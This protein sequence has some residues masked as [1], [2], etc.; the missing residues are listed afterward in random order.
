MPS[1]PDA[2]DR[3][4][5]QVRGVELRTL[6]HYQDR[7]GALAVAEL[8]EM[9]PFSVERLFV[10]YAV[11]SPEVR[12]EHA[13]RALHQFLICVAGSCRVSVDDGENRREVL[14]DS[15]AQGLYI[16][17]MIWSVQHRHTPDAVMVVLASAPYDPDDYI[18][19]YAE[20]VALIRATR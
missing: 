3:D 14:L 5:R 17:P 10:V 18:R 16:P 6:P 2:A 9:V 15:P 8:R 19:D 12:G 20:F 13:H 4:V 7:R 11:P 1:P